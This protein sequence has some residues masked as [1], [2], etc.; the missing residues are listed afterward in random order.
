MTEK[1]RKKELIRT[2]RLEVKKE[3]YQCLLS[4]SKKCF[5]KMQERE[6]FAKLT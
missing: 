1:S 6:K 4:K 2:Q 3:K 5:F